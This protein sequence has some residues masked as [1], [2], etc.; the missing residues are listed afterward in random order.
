MGSFL[1]VPET[2]ILAERI[3]NEK[4]I[5]GSCSIN[6]KRTSMEDTHIMK[7]LNEKQYLFAVFDGHGGNEC[8][9]Y[10][11]NHLVELLQQ[12]QQISSS[13][14]YTD[15][16]LIDIDSRYRLVLTQVQSLLSL[17]NQFA[18]D[19]GNAKAKGL[20]VESLLESSAKVKEQIPLLEEEGKLL[21]LHLDQKLPSIPNMPADD[22]PFCC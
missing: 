21:K 11:E 18:K 16:E 10:C 5:A 13:D 9:E 8:S 12:T 6:G 2:S 22:V 1:S 4:F 15:E 3:G 14:L 19:I 7:Q 20:D 17:R